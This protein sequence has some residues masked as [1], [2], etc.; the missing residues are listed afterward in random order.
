MLLVKGANPNAVDIHYGQSALSMATARGHGAVVS[1]LLR[2]GAE[3]NVRDL[4][5]QWTLLHHAVHEGHVDIAGSLLGHGAEVANFQDQ[6]IQ[7]GP[8]TWVD[9]VMKTLRVTIQK[10]FHNG[11][12]THA[13]GQDSSNSSHESGTPGASRSNQESN[14]IRKRFWKENSSFSGG[15]GDGSGNNPNKRLRLD[16]A[17]DQTDSGSSLR[18]ACPYFKYDPMR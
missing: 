15:S 8:W 12:R 17:L 6:A 5:S 7:K 2:Y 11:L 18:L 16:P 14:G 1:Q 9:R 13:T 10:G 3:I 4:Y